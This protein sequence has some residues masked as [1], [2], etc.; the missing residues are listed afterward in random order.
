V[1][2]IL[3]TLFS[4]VKKLDWLAL[5]FFVG[6]FL[7]LFEQFLVYGDWFTIS[8]I[9]HETFAVGFVTLGIGLLLGKKLRKF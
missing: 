9:H 8:Q 1:D 7:I 4:F 2:I 6:A 3:K 5:S